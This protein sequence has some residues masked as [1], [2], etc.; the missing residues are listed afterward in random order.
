MEK[1]SKNLY[2]ILIGVVLVLLVGAFTILRPH[3]SKNN[4][5]ADTAKIEDTTPKFDDSKG[6]KPDELLKKIT[7]KENMLIIDVRDANSFNQEHILNSQNI[8]MTDLANLGSA[9]KDKTVVLVDFDGSDS[10]NLNKIISSQNGGQNIFFLIGGFSAWRASF[11]PTITDANPNSFADQSK[12]TYIKT[13]QL[14]DLMGKESNLLIIDLRKQEDY[15]TGHIKGAINIFLGDLEKKGK[16]I[17]LG[18]K[19]ILYDR[20]GLWAFKGAVK[21]YDMGIFNVSAL[22]DGFDAWKQKGFEIVK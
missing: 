3:F 9:P 14:K 17:P 8:P 16:D 21:L 19:I 7:A 12:V 22:G 4:T 6:L 1:N 15:Q 2:A 18:K 11:G 13:D 5:P 20:D 10:A